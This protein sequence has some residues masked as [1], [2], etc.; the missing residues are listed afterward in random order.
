MRA[1]ILHGHCDCE[2]IGRFRRR[3]WV[4]GRRLTV[5]P[6]LPLQAELCRI[7]LI[8][9]PWH[10]DEHG[11]QAGHHSRRR[12]STTLARDPYS[13]P[14]SRCAVP[15]SSVSLETSL[16]ATG[17]FWR[18]V[19]EPPKISEIQSQLRTSFKVYLRKDRCFCL[20]EVRAGS[21]ELNP[22]IAGFVC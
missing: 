10:T 3:V 19:S 12:C 15:R 4:A 6:T 8:T 16:K 18:Y 13:M 9:W 22:V 11:A 17:M 7:Q 14:E 1:V 21:D 2:K 5:Y 20:R